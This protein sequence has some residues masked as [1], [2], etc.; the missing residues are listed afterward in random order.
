MYNANIITAQLKV[1]KY[2]RMALLFNRFSEQRK[3]NKKT[4]S[5]DIFIR[6][7][8][9]N[10]KNHEKQN[11][12]GGLMKVKQMLLSVDIHGACGHLAHDSRKYVHIW[13]PTIGYKCKNLSPDI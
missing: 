2:P 12:N 6:F 9:L 4:Q 13:L 7:H 10:T 3:L 11:K 8:V 5:E 1:V